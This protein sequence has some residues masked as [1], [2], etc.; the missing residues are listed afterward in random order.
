MS[1][2]AGRYRLEQTDVDE[3][4]EDETPGGGK[5]GRLS[6][7][8]TSGAMRRAIVPWVLLGVLLAACGPV[9]AVNGAAGPVTTTTSQVPVTTPSVGVPPAPQPATKVSS[10]PYLKTQDAA[11]DNGQRVG[12]V[13]VSSGADGQPHP[14]CFY[15]TLGIHL[16]LTIW[17]Y[18]GDPNVATAIVNQSAPIAT[19][20]PETTPAGWRGGS[21]PLT[22]G[23]V[24]AVAKGGDAVVVTSNQLQTI[25]CRLVTVQVITNLGL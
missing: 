20:N 22:N 25:K 24:Y 17:V 21:M 18:V 6:V 16:Q 8:L 12:E 4:C 19:S 7:W 2:L 14:A 11:D 9:T 15:Y 3:N 5:L 23:A 1:C 13:K 10:C